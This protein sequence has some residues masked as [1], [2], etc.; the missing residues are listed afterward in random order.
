MIKLA[1]TREVLR[2][3]IFI[4]FFRRCFCSVQGL[5]QDDICTERFLHLNGSLSS[6]L[7]FAFHVT[8]I[9]IV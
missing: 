8:I 3:D 5:I 7:G 9:I 2:N 6:A 1:L 4:A